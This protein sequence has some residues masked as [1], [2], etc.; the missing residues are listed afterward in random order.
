M[1]SHEQKLLHPSSLEVVAA[2][3]QAL[4]AG[5]SQAMESLQAQDY[6]LDF[7]TQDAWGSGPLTGEEPRNFWAAWFEGFPEMDFQ[8]TRT[9]AAEEV[10]VTQWVFTGTNTGP[11]PPI[12]EPQP[13]PTGKTIRFRGIS[14][15][16]VADGLIQRETTYIDLGTLLV[17]LGVVL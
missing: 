2:Y 12:I 13:E 11:M 9:I 1:Q 6:V 17:E 4:A 5:D 14:V 8:V 15:Y 7:V 10:V 16:D 3:T